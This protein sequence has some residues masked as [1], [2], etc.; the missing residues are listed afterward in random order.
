MFFKKRKVDEWEVGHILYDFL[1]NNNFK[2]DIYITYEVTKKGIVN[3][4]TTKP[5]LLIG[6]QGINIDKIT[7]ELK[8]RAN[9]KGIK[10][11]ETKHFVSCNSYG[12]V[13]YK[14]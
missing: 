12:N 4:N 5:G 9:V 1:K 11:Y 7:K 10:L 14:Y 2:N 3:I 8:E 13:H 6:L